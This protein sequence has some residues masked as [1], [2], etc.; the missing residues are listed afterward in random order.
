MAAYMNKNTQR[1]NKIGH[2]KAHTGNI[3]IKLH[4]KYAEKLP[5]QEK[6]VKWNLDY[7]FICKTMD[8]K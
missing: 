4:I 5:Q 6:Q 8:F 3:N 1:V 2:Y 7:I